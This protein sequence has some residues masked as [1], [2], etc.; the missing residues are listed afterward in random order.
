MG[1]ARSLLAA[2]ALSTLG[3]CNSLHLYNRNADELA[4]A[5]NA[6][7]TDSKLG[8]MLAGQR[9]ALDALEKRE[10]AAFRALTMAQ[11]DG[12]LLALMTDSEL[13]GKQRTVGDGFAARFK[14]YVDE[15]LTQLDGDPDARMRLHKAWRVDRED[16][17]ELQKTVQIDRRVLKTYDAAVVLPPCGQELYALETD[18]TGE[19][20]F[21]LTGNKD[22]ASVK[23]IRTRWDAIHVSIK[24]LIANCK[25][26]ETQTAKVDGFKAAPRSE[27]ESALQELGAL[28]K[29]AQDAQQASVTQKKALR[30]ATAEL[31]A[32]T[33]G[34]SSALA[35]K[36]LRCPGGAQA[37]APAPPSGLEGQAAQAHKK[38][39]DAL[40]AL[41]KAGDRGI[42]VVAEEKLD[43]I[44]TVLAAMSGMSESEPGAGDETVDRSL[45]LIAASSRLGQALER[46][47]LADELPPLEPL[48]IEKQLAEVELAYANAGV[49]IAQARLRH[50]RDRV[51]AIHDELRMLVQA[52]ST[53]GGMGALPAAAPCKSGVACASFESLLSEN[54]APAK[55]PH[56]RMAYRAMALLSESFSSARDRQQT[57]QVSMAALDYQ[58]ALSR[59]E[60]AVGSWKALV[61]TPLAQLK[62]YHAQGLRPEVAA[63]ILQALGVVGIAVK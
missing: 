8:D 53:I 21:E 14:A 1:F 52:R 25:E 5:A 35:G 58:E 2:V 28:E 61:D 23:K 9:T 20:F 51:D 13:P 4:T 54:S 12:A 40:A 48:V 43:R 17:A 11:R 49:R 22:E 31:A 18:T 32:A 19:R 39:C 45:A 10:I 30:E 50:A 24:T 63:A 38:L 55:A 41:E 37:K 42:Q 59:S 33:K 6:D 29:A 46:Y 60:A 26:L 16:L 47:R 3:A 36:D 62:A 27:L 7:Y 44:Y 56:Y 15:R 57:A 34:M